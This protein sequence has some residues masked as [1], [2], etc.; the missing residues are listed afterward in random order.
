[1]QQDD[2]SND[3]Q[4]E[5]NVEQARQ[6]VHT[7]IVD[8]I[9]NPAEKSAFLKIM[10]A[11][12]GTAR[13]AFY[14]F[15][16]ALIAS[17]DKMLVPFA[18][19]CIARAILYVVP[20]FDFSARTLSKELENPDTQGKILGALVSMSSSIAYGA[21]SVIA[22]E[23][24]K[25]KNNSSDSGVTKVLTPIYITSAAIA[26][27]LPFV[28]FCR[29]YGKSI[30]QKIANLFASNA[31]EPTEDAVVYVSQNIELGGNQLNTNQNNESQP[32]N[33]GNQAMQLSQLDIPKGGGFSNFSTIRQEESIENKAIKALQPKRQ[34]P[35]IQISI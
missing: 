34:L 6:I 11:L 14:G 7:E 18:Y 1:M 8:K 10:Y 21:A 13:L 4:Q 17:P 30:K 27:F 15:C 32:V 2:C 31:G 3:N 5:L 25:N 16:I 26:T 22:I 12:S 19:A 33:Q 24:D 35:K 23:A 29:K 20:G 9:K 28:G